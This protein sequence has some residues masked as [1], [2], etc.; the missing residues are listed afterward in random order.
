MT[1][2]RSISPFIAVAFAIGISEDSIFRFFQVGLLTSAGGKLMLTALLLWV[3]VFSFAVYRLR[4]R[5]LWLLLS[6]PLV[7]LPYS[8]AIIGAGE[9]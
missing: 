2:H 9:I 4:L 7:A 6:L 5:S 3:T 1:S 8:L